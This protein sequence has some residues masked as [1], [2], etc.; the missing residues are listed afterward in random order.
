MDHILLDDIN[1]SRGLDVHT[2]LAAL[3]DYTGKTGI[4]KVEEAGETEEFSQGKGGR[5][6]G[7]RTPAEFRDL[8]MHFFAYHQKMG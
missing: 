3:R 2:R 6:G 1:A 7:V 5:Q 4:A 8:I